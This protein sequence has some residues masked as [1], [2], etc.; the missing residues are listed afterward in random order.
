MYI[1]PQY[2]TENDPTMRRTQQGMHYDD[3]KALSPNR[4]SKK[5]YSHL[6][7]N[8]VHQA[9]SAM[10]IADSA[11]NDD[12]FREPKPLVSMLKASRTNSKVNI[13]GGPSFKSI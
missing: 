12:L 3:A 11:T 13:T 7:R 10:S 1:E 4:H 2:F 9:S 5:S 8:Q 6:M